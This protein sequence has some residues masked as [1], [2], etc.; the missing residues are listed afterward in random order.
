MIISDRLPS[1]IQ[2]ICEE[3]TDAQAACIGIWI[4]AGSSRETLD[5]AGISH[6]IE[7][8]LFKG[9]EKRSAREIARDTDNIG[10]SVNAFTG[11]EATC[12]HMKALTEKFPEAVEILLDMLCH[13]VFDPKEIRKER[14]VILEEMQMIQDTPD[15][16][17]IDLL[18]GTV[19][20]DTDL[21][22]S[23]IGTKTSLH[24][25]TRE[26]ILDYIDR[27]YTRDNIVVSVVGNFDRQRLYEQLEEAL[28]SFPQMRHESIE[29]RIPAGQ[30]FLAKAKDV[31]QTHLAIGRTGVSLSSELYYA[32]AVVNDVL[33]GSM[34]SRLFQN[35]RED[36]G[37]AYTVYS[38]CSSYL[39]TG[40]YYIYA[41]VGL[42]KEAETLDAI[43]SEL[44]L[45][46]QEGLASEEVDIVKQRLKSGYIFSLES[47]NSRMYR[48]GKNM[49]LLGR[50]FTPEEVMAEIDAVTQDEILEICR[51]IGDLSAYSGVSISKEKLDVKKLM[52]I[53]S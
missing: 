2:V 10:A 14:G 15:D 21:A 41:G 18:T 48:L 20:K 11:K 53:R 42:G 32:Q 29:T 22:S 43:A 34:S 5:Q 49:L 47:M 1:G 12:Y 45:L 40:M 51:Q 33:G 7:H 46:K 50:Y 26:H 37:L 13:S 35:I 9:T 27:Y 3:I 28:A 36:R 39:R 4:G 31:G 24:K 6:L 19:L 8:M 30:R 44:K 16:H 17:I 23:I 52:S 25:I 38:A